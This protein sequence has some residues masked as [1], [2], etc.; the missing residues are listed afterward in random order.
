MLQRCDYIFS[1]LFDSA[2]VFHDHAVQQSPSTE[3][4]EVRYNYIVYPS[5]HYNKP[6]A[7]ERTNREQQKRSRPALPL[8]LSL[9]FFSV[10]R[11]KPLSYMQNVVQS[12]SSHLFLSLP[13]ALSLSLYLSRRDQSALVPRSTWCDWGQS[14]YMLKSCESAVQN[15]TRA[16][17]DTRRTHAASL[18][19]PP[20]LQ[21]IFDDVIILL[22]HTCN[23][24]PVNIN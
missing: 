17:T 1:I 8:Q 10:S 16:S 6:N 12:S 5:L 13:L 7:M 15:T 2:T 24:A 4:M 3:T 18:P 22:R 9:C 23:T 19:P 21:L 11:L 20:L 14:S